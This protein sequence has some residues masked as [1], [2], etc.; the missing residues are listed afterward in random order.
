METHSEYPLNKINSCKK[1]SPKNVQS[2]AYLI[3]MNIHWMCFKNGYR[4]HKHGELD[5]KLHRRIESDRAQ[6]FLE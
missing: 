3:N 4:M 5:H 2:E 1:L 6:D